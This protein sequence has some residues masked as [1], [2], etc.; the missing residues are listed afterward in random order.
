VASY[1][2]NNNKT[3]SVSPSVG[4]KEQAGKYTEQYINA[5]M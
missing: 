1:H 3:P 4:K 5:N 2:K